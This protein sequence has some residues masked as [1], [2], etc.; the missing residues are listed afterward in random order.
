MRTAP[1]RARWNLLPDTHP[2]LAA[3]A[4]PAAARSAPWDQPCFA[5]NK[6]A[7]VVEVLGQAGVASSAVLAG[8]GLKAEQLHDP[9]TLTST[10]QL[11]RVVSSAVALCPAPDLGWRIGQRL[12]I[13]SYGLY[14][15]ALLCAPSMRAGLDLATRHHVLANPLVPIHLAETDSAFVWVFPRRADLGLPGLD[16]RTYRVLIV[17]QMAIHQALTRD[18]MGADC[19]PSLVAFSWPDSADDRAAAQGFGC[20]QRFGQPRNE[21]H[22]ARHWLDRQPQL[23]DALSAA[24]A[25]HACARL[26]QQ[27]VGGSESMSRRV[28]GELMRTPGRFPGIEHIAE[29][30]HMTGRTLRRHLQAE[31][32]SYADLLSSVRRALAEDYLRSTRMSI[33]DIASALSYG[34]ARSFRQAFVRWT[35]RPPSDY[36]RSA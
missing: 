27:L 19:A 14:G 23:A 11:Y 25:S 5:P 26:V 28:Y 2:V 17:M 31:G 12:R 24:Q 10:A 20:P 13:T 34:D 21:L 35:G 3:P 7:A 22:F 6:I 8:T 32:A 4:L 16:E 1:A 33:E 9:D 18:V 29:R 36:R 30:L 15:Y